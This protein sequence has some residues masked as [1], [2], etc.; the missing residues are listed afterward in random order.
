[1]DNPLKAFQEPRE[2]KRLK[3]LGLAAQRR[4]DREARFPSFSMISSTSS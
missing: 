1:M 2:F 3:E 4:R